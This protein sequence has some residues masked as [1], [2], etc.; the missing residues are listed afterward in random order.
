LRLSWSEIFPS[1]TQQ[2]FS[3]SGQ[4]T[5]LNTY[6]IAFAISSLKWIFVQSLHEALP[7]PLEVSSFAEYARSPLSVVISSCEH[8]PNPSK[9]PMGSTLSPCRPRNTVPSVA[10]MLKRMSGIKRRIQERA[11]R[12]Q[13]HTRLIGEIP[14]YGL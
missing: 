9:L 5:S 13:R 14:C 10:M 11:G 6:A 7:V 12:S 1:C 2:L 8:P 3:S 4:P